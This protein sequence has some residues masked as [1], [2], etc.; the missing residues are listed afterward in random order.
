M[1]VWPTST[2]VFGLEHVPVGHQR[3]LVLRV[4]AGD[5]ASEDVAMRQKHSPIWEKAVNSCVEAPAKLRSLLARSLRQ[6]HPEAEGII[7]R[8]LKD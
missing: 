8:C 6:L 1:A 4:R 3:C 2:V 7:D 5:S